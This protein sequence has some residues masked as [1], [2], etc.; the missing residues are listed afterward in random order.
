MAP[1]RGAR[2][3]PRPCGPRRL[4][5]GALL[6]SL[7]VAA[8]C[9]RRAPPPDLSPDPAA[10][11]AEV[12]R[13]QARVQRVSGEARVKILSPGGD[14]TVTQFVVAERPDRLRL[15][16]LDFFGNPA[17]VLVTDGGRFALLDLRK[18]VF[19]RG[20][21]T[22]ENLARLL[23]LAIPAEELVLLLCGAA[24]IAAGRP[25]AVEPGDGVLRL[26][27][28]AA[29]RVQRLDVGAGAAVH[30]STV[31]ALP[32][33]SPRPAR[34]D[35]TFGRFR[36]RAGRPFPGTVR[37]EAPGS[38]VRVD[39]SWKEIEVNA[40]LPEG[41]FTLAPPPGARIVDLDER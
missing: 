24:P 9:A 5:R 36:D 14:G 33:L 31:S 20:A 8:A 26:T 15:D 3:T 1:T 22:P 41:S 6:L 2:P 39:L 17:A 21:A 4:A 37:L 27:V 28:E 19:F 29:D 38:G 23:P 11:L 40:V 13:T 18:G 34:Y 7:A 32:G 10:L 16:T 25:T 30:A 12:E 35:V